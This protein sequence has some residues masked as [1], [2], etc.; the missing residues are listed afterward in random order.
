M[1]NDQL[2]EHYKG[3]H[4]SAYRKEQ[5]VTGDEIILHG[6]RHTLIMRESGNELREPASLMDK[7][8]NLAN[9]IVDAVIN[10]R[11][12]LADHLTIEARLQQCHACKWYNKA[13]KTC[14]S[15]GCM[16]EAKVRFARTKCPEGVWQ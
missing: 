1:T 3:R 4:I 16:T 9:V 5:R 13:S 11:G 6:T 14:R 8:Q 15:C 10:P 12:A 2:I 7:A